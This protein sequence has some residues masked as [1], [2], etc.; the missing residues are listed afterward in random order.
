MLVLILCDGCSTVHCPGKKCLGLVYTD[1]E[2]TFQDSVTSMVDNGFV[3]AK[4]IGAK[5]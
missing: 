2:L 1:M 5:L 3:P 4:L